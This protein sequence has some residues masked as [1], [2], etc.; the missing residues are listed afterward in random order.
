[1]DTITLTFNS[2][3]IEVLE[4][5]PEFVEIVANMPA[6]I[7]YTLDGTLPTMLSTQYT[8]AI[9]MPTEAGSVTL[10]AVAYFLDGY[11]NLVP[12]SVMSQTYQTDSSVTGER[13]RRLDFTGIV[14]IYPGG[15]DIPFWYDSAG[16][17]KVLI[18]IEKEELELALIPS[19]RE[20]DG[21]YRENVA[22]GVV[23]LV[24]PEE[25]PSTVDDVYKP[26][27]SPDDDPSF[28][29]D[30]LFIVIDGREPRDLNTVNLT[31]GPY[32]SLRDPEKHFG[33]L[34]FISTDGS[35]YMSGSLTKI[36]YNREREIA[37]FYYFDSNVNRWIKSIQHLPRVTKS[38]PPNAVISHPVVFKWNNFGRHQ[39]V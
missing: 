25:T 11:N 8:S 6:M 3:G 38:I 2:L 18:D 19:E 12:S 16:E 9:Q 35:N 7:F 33:G 5:I 23:S 37:V 22:G 4:G 26:F 28:D 31:N 34:D 14:Y 20:P 32:M 30:A 27:S 39:A 10:S 29:P 15:L 17:P 24:P 21:S 1:M 36:H 13:V